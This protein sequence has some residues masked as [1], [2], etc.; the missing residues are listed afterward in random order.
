MATVTGL[1][2]SAE[3]VDGVLV[4]YIGRGFA[5]VNPKMYTQIAVMGGFAALKLPSPTIKS[6]GAKYNDQQ[7]AVL[8]EFRD[9]L[10]PLEY[11]AIMAHEL[12]HVHN[13]DYEKNPSRKKTVFTDLE[14]EL[15]ADRAGVEKCGPLAMKNAILK[16][17][18]HQ[19]K[20]LT[21]ISNE[22]VA[23]FIARITRTSIM[24]K[25]LK[26]LDAMM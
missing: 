18:L 2:V 8:T 25:R 12:S 11:E 20:V 3:V 24:K 4:E 10:T 22:K 9:I 26:A 7:I 23:G 15:A 13:K 16:S 17:Q 19:T 14:V 21:K 5:T 6:P 1:F